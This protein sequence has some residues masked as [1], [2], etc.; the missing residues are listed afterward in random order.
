M[1][2]NFEKYITLLG[3]KT[4]PYPYIKYADMMVHTS[5]VESQGLTILE[6][7]ALKTPCVA[8][9]S[10]GPKEYLN[11]KNGY[12]ISLDSSSMYEIV[13]RAIKDL[14]CKSIV[15]HAYETVLDNYAPDSIANKFNSL[16]VH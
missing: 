13:L 3:A 16:I 15:D 12:P 9:A 1:K 10:L 11:E 7:M 8:V 4:N 14:P 2:Y 5:H 6:A